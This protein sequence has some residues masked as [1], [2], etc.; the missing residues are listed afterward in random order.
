[1]GSVW[2]EWMD[3]RPVMALKRKELGI[4]KTQMGKLFSYCFYFCMKQSF[5]WYFSFVTMYMCELCKNYVL[6][7]YFF[8][9]LPY[10]C[11]WNCVKIYVN[12]HLT[13]IDFWQKKKVFWMKFLD[14]LAYK[15]K[16]WQRRKKWKGNFWWIIMIDTINLDVWRRFLW[17]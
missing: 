3:L 8:T 9:T 14:L 4:V 1:M 11:F 15:N 16:F 10:T 6:F 5:I 13:W 12:V 17:V 7:F 2:Y